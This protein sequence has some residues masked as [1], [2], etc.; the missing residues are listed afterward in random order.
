MIDLELYQAV[1]KRIETGDCILWKS[2]TIIG[3]LI[4]MWSP[5]FNHVSLALHLTQH[6]CLEDR[7]WMLEAL[8]H[9]ITLTLLSRR[10]MDF[11]GEA[12]LLPVRKEFAHHRPFVAS[13]ALNNIGVRYD[14][15]SLFQNMLGHV[16]AEAKSF[17]CSEFY[18]MAWCDA[19]RTDFGFNHAPRPSDVHRMGIFDNPVRIF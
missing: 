14:Y 19:M 5:R 9:G 15:K 17:F 11:K 4:R 3:K 10:L 1:H 13:W 6:E 18:Y 7:R 16:S 2:N 8:E 12:W